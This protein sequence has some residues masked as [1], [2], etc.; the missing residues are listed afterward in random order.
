MRQTDFVYY[1]IR[2]IQE[3][4]FVFC[5]VFL[6][7]MKEEIRTVELVLGEMRQK[8]SR[9]TAGSDDSHCT[10]HLRT[11]SVYELSFYV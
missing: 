4:I 6:V 10:F 8:L 5:L 1:F 3:V 9:T 2:A 11:T 7:L